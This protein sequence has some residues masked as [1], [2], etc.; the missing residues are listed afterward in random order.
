M[1]PDLKSGDCVIATPLSEYKAG[2]I[3]IFLYGTDDIII[4]RIVKIDE[5]F[6]CCKGD[7]AFGIERVSKK[8]ILG[9]AVLVNSAPIPEWSNWKM[10]LSYVLALR[11][12]R[13]NC[14]ITETKNLN[15]YKLY[16]DIV[17]RVEMP[18]TLY[19]VKKESC[20]V[21]KSEDIT[22]KLRYLLSSPCSKEALLTIIK[23]QPQLS[24]DDVYMALFKL[25]LTDEV[26]VLTFNEFS[27]EDI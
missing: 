11:F 27:A 14:N 3:V 8:S 20:L 24:I 18:K 19:H 17:L 26:D 9:K 2:D 13:C 4:H 15:L 22:D 5:R 7:N 10:D 1:L 16:S 12:Y 23:K 6:Y 21:K 25:V